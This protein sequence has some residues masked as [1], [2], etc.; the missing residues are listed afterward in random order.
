MLS[1]VL[2]MELAVLRLVLDLLDQFLKSIVV[3]I[4]PTRGPSVLSLPAPR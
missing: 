2:V 1:P 3:F 4:A